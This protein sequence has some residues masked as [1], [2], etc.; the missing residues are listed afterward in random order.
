MKCEF[1]FT[2]EVVALKILEIVVVVAVKD[3]N[4][5]PLLL[6]K[7]EIDRHLGDPLRI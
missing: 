2:D 3:P 7:V 6:L 5:K 4:F 1:K